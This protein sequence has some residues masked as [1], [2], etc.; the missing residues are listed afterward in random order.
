MSFDMENTPREFSIENGNEA[1]HFALNAMSGVITVVSTPT[2]G[3]HTL[4][5]KVTETEGTT[6]LSATERLLVK[7]TSSMPAPTL[8]LSATL[9]DAS[10][11]ANNGAITKKVLDEVG[12]EVLPGIAGSL[13]FTVATTGGT[14]VTYTMTINDGP[15][16]TSVPPPFTIGS[17][18]GEVKYGTANGLINFYNEPSYD[19][20]STPYD[21][22][23]DTVAAVLVI[24]ATDG[25]SAST[26]SFTVTVSFGPDPG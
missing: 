1:G 3:T 26:A 4:N 25:V 24:T 16:T 9:P 5:V 18:S 22:M 13:V 11:L 19:G 2:P 6:P 20:K 8:S 10:T 12:E 17:S 15:M 7:V 14:D 21:M 23:T